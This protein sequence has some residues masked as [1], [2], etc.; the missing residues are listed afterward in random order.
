MGRWLVP[1]FKGLV[2]GPCTYCYCRCNP[3]VLSDPSGTQGQPPL[4]GMIGNDPRIG[5]LWERAV[6]ETLGPR[7]QAQTYEDVVTAFQNQVASRIAA[8]GGDL[9]SNREGGTAIHYA[10]RSY[11]AVRTAFGRLAAQSGISLQGIQVHHTFDELARVPQEALTTTNLMFA[12]G[13]AGTVGSGHNFAHQVSDALAAGAR[14]PG[15]EVVA[16]LDAAGIVPDVPELSATIREPS[17]PSTASTAP[18]TP[19]SPTASASRTTGTTRTA[20]ALT[21]ARDAGS[22][23]AR[24]A[25]RAAPTAARVLGATARGGARVLGAV[26]RVAAPLAIAES[27]YRLATATN[28]LDRLQ[29]GADTA[30]GAAAYAGP[31]GTAFSAGYSAGQ[32][33]DVG[34]EAATGESL[35][36]RGARGLE[37]VDRAISSVLPADESLPEYR[38][39]N[40]IAWWLIDTFNL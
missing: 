5:A 2:D 22:A 40:R 30:A 24:T 9:G 37:S 35:S 27:S 29:A 7:L 1:D 17:S 4:P 14:N 26:G 21:R 36:S 18:R 33:L 15:Q 34:V 32:L 11:Q 39:E 10:R 25:E 3:I 28:D 23:L 38:R 12:R 13:N 20:R 6:V 31:V 16:N 19:A 8:H